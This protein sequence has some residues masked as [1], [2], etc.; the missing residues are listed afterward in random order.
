M[1]VSLGDS[2]F[3]IKLDI[4]RVHFDNISVRVIQAAQ[5]IH[6]GTSVQMYRIFSTSQINLD[7]I[8]G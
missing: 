8:S 1:N 2:T 4:S 7:I 3:T 6:V 5:I